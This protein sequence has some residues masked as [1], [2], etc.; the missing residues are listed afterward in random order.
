M[1]HVRR[2]RATL[3]RRKLRRSQRGAHALAGQPRRLDV[4]R[5]HQRDIRVRRRAAAA[6]VLGVPGNARAGERDALCDGRAELSRRFAGAQP[7]GPGGSRRSRNVTA[8]SRGRTAT[9][10]CQDHYTEKLAYIAGGYYTA[11]YGAYGTYRSADEGDRPFGRDRRLRVCNYNNLYKVRR[12]RTDHRR[13][14]AACCSFACSLLSSFTCLCV[15]LLVCLLA[16][17]CQGGTDSVWHLA[18]CVLWYRRAALRAH[19]CAARPYPSAPPH[20]AHS[21]GCA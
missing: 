9:W 1:R 10:R 21:C 19:I 12:A 15:C 17:L 3:G 5:P 7:M 16:C 4:A 20:C 18:R 6:R 8:H 11:D 14:C 2:P 13:P